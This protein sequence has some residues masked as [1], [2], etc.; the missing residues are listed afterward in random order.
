MEHDVYFGGS[1]RLVYRRKRAGQLLSK[2]RFLSAQMLA[3]LNNDLWLQNAGRA[4]VLAAEVATAFENATG[5]RLA[6]PVEANEV[7][8]IM[9]RHMFDALQAAGSNFYEW[10]LDGLAADDVCGRFVLSFATPQADVDQLIN[11]V[12]RLAN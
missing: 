11:L 1:H 8:P 12:K 2:G 10:P 4:N 9:P 6:A 7:F 3:Y 5:V